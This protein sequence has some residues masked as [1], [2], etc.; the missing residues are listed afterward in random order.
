MAIGGSL[1]PCI[2]TPSTLRRRATFRQ[3]LLGCLPQA[4][5]P[6]Q[7]WQLDAKGRAGTFLIG[8]DAFYKQDREGRLVDIR[9]GA[10]AFF[11]LSDPNG[12]HLYIGQKE[13]REKRM[14]SIL[15]MMARGE[16]FHP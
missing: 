11:S 4:V 8:L 13:T 7:K 10:E 12:W 3:T 14:K 1:R 16:K 6:G 9:G 2:T 15:A 5:C